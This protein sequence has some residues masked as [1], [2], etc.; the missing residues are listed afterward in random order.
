MGAFIFKI[1]KTISTCFMSIIPAPFPLHLQHVKSC[2][3]YWCGT[4]G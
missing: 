2:N 4:G 1:K 3:L